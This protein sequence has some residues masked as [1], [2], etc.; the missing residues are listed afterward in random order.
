MANLGRPPRPARLR[1]LKGAPPGKVNLNEPVPRSGRVVPPDGLGEEARTIW[2]Y[3][4][5]ELE[6]MRSSVPTDRDA[7]V[8]YCEAVVNHRRATAQLVDAPLLIRG[9]RGV[10]VR[11]PLLAVQRDA[12]HLI[13]QFAQEFGLTPSARARI[14]VDGPRREEDNPF[15]QGAV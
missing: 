1:L 4:L 2:D 8:A 10:Q 6:F 12:A 9:H 3:T 5:A 7:L 15:S 13:R 14:D 11:N